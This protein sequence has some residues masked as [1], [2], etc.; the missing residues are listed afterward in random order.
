MRKKTKDKRKHLYS[1]ATH[2]Y[3]HKR[4]TFMVIVGL[5]NKETMSGLASRLELSMLLTLAATL[6]TTYAPSFTV[7]QQFQPTQNMR[8]HSYSSSLCS[9]ATPFL[10]VL[11]Q[12]WNFSNPYTSKFTKMTRVGFRVAVGGDTM[13]VRALDRASTTHVDRQ[14]VQSELS[15]RFPIVAHVVVHVFLLLCFFPSRLQFI[16]RYLAL[17]LTSE[18]VAKVTSTWPNSFLPSSVARLQDIS[19][20]A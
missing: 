3:L 9:E 12:C 18:L 15:L 10:H 1:F 6:Y 2:H 7:N 11:K 5:V 20:P 17:L 4:C 13:N 14:R 8:P 19:T 16:N